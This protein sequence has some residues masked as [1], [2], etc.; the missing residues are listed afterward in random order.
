MCLCTAMLC[1]FWRTPVT[2]D[3]NFKV[4]LDYYWKMLLLNWPLPLCVFAIMLF[5]HFYFQ[6]NPLF[7]WKMERPPSI[8]IRTCTELLH[9]GDTCRFSEQLVWHKCQ[10]DNWSGSIEHLQTA[11]R[12]LRPG[13]EDS[14][15]F[16]LC[17][18]IWSLTWFYLWNVKI[19][20]CAD[21]FCLTL[22]T[23]PKVSSIVVCLV[24]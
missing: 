21:A 19:F 6:T 20:L 22:K 2:Q 18:K 5:S 8:M 7:E 9:T 1:I 3:I 12:R 15:T 24:M 14:F 11:M 4:F 10:E 13:L 16:E 23:H 17:N